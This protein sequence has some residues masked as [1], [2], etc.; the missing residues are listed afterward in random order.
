MAA[1]SAEEIS[2]MVQ[3]NFAHINLEKK[4]STSLQDSLDGHIKIVSYG[5][6][7]LPS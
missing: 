3:K 1:K 6:F 4:E 2:S 7:S 5:C